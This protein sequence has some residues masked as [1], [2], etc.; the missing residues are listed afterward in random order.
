[1]NLLLPDSFERLLAE[2]ALKLL[3]TNEGERPVVKGADWVVL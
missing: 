1:M 2:A 3:L